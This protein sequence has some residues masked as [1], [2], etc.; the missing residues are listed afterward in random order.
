VSRGPEESYTLDHDGYFGSDNNKEDSQSKLIVSRKKLSIFELTGSKYTFM[1][2]PYTDYRL[3]I[4]T[5]VILKFIFSQS[6]KY[7]LYLYAIAF[8]RFTFYPLLTCFTKPGPIWV[9]LKEKIIEKATLLTTI[10]EMFLFSTYHK[11][12]Y[13]NFD[14]GWIICNE[15]FYFVIFSIIIYNSYKRNLRLDYF[16]LITLALLLGGKFTVFYILFPNFLPSMTFQKHDFY[17]ILKNPFYNM[18]FV[19]LGLFFGMLNYCIQRSISCEKLRYE[20]KNFLKL[21]IKFL[22]YYKNNRFIKVLVTSIFSLIVFFLVI[23]SF[24]FIYRSYF[25]ESDPYMTAFFTDF[26]VNLY[27]LYDIEIGI[28]FLYMIITPLQLSGDN[29][30]FSMLK[31]NNWNI[32]SKPYTSYMLTI[33]MV[34]I[35]VFNYSENRVKVQFYNILFFSLLST[36]LLIFINSAIYIFIESPLRRINK[37]LLE[38]HEEAEEMS[39]D[40]ENKINS[41]KK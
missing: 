32:F 28:F 23:I 34:I 16:L 38:K 22:S 9:Y 19:I 6:Y 33:S 4:K 26:W 8:F 25:M 2:H 37:F 31:S 20:R 15:I 39:V 3:K 24:V 1:Y 10:A 17:Y 13:F 21:P 27:M 11:S 12:L 14:I 35:Y 7:L 36:T 41:N 5:E 18:S 30:I 29:F 40:S